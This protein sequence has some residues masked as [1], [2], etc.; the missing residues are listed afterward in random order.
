MAIMATVFALIGAYLVLQVGT[1][2]FGS[3]MSGTLPCSN[4]C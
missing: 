2:G 4:Y 1:A 3:A